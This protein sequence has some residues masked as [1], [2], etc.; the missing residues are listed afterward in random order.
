M[1]ILGD[2]NIINIFNYMSLKDTYKCLVVSKHISKLVNKSLEINRV[3]NRIMLSKYIIKLRYNILYNQLNY[4]T[5]LLYYT[6]E[7]NQL[8]YNNRIK[9]YL[10][11]I[12]IFYSFIQ[13]VSMLLIL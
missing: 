2:D 12:S 11:K 5:E 4:T 10:V 3:R 9:D 6:R 7:L 8:N 13:L 1:D